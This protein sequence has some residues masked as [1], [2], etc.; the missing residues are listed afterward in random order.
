[1][2]LTSLLFV[3]KKWPKIIDEGNGQEQIEGANI[4]PEELRT[5]Y[6][7]SYDVDRDV[8]FVERIPASP[9]KPNEAADGDQAPER[10][11]GALDESVVFDLVNS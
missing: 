11:S 5:F 8:L 9:D 3:D 10:K 6:L 7:C 2:A 4:D 1:M